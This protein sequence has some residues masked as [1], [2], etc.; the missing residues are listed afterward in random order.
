MEEDNKRFFESEDRVD[1]FYARCVSTLC[2]E[3]DLLR[4]FSYGYISWEMGGSKKKWGGYCYFQ[5][6]KQRDCLWHP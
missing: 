1:K 2:R 3:I 4:L 5:T 6:L